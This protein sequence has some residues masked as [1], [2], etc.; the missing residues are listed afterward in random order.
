MAL[1]ATKVPFADASPAQIRAAIVPEDRDQFDI[2]L[3]RALD[4][5]AAT[6]SLDPLAEFLAHWRRLAWVQAGNGHDSY[7]GM[8]AKADRILAT[9]QPEPGARPWDEIKAELGL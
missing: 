9:S 5:V 1:T 2:S 4:A 7:R 3:R 6:L 8:L